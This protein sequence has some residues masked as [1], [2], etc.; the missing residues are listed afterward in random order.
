MS[1]PPAINFIIVGETFRIILQ[2]VNFSLLG[3]HIQVVK[4]PGE[5]GVDYYSIRKV[6]MILVADS[7]RI[8]SFEFFLQAITQYKANRNVFKTLTKV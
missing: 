6:K 5:S 2:P 1:D 7:F 3:E 8:A 4:V